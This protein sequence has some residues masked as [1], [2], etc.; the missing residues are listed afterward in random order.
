[1]MIGAC[2]ACTLMLILIIV[3]SVTLTAKKRAKDLD[4][5]IIVEQN[6]N[7]QQ[8]EQTYEA[9]SIVEETVSIDM[10]DILSS[11]GFGC[12]NCQDGDCQECKPDYLKGSKDGKGNCKKCSDLMLNCYTCS[13]ET[14]CEECAL[15]YA[16]S[17]VFFGECSVGS[18]AGGN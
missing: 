17:Y 11:C 1:M 5:T 12:T 2:I 6:N 7:E 14:V 3:L 4:L 15:G 9:P 16:R 13:S 18:I 10:T 8:Y